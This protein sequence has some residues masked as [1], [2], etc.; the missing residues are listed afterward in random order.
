[1]SLREVDGTAGAPWERPL[2]GSLDR[3]VVQSELLEGNPLGDPTRRPLYIYQPPGLARRGGGPVPS[4]YVL[5]GFTGQLDMW[6]SRAEFAPNI[7]ERLDAM[8]AAG[9]CPDAVIVFVDAWTS[10]GGSQ[11]LN[12]SSTG[13]YLDYICDEIVPFVDERYPTLADRDHRGLSGKS[14]GGYGAM[15]VPMLRPDVFGALASHAG[16]A[17]FECCYLPSFPGVARQLRDDFDGSFDVFLER[18]AEAETFEFRRFGEPLSVWGYACAYSPDPTRPGR[19]LIPFDIATGRLE[20]AI[21]RRWLA[22]DPVR[23]A[24]DHAGALDSMRRIYLDAGRSDEWFLDL[25]A[26]A[27]SQELTSLGVRHTLELFDGR[28]GGISYRYPGAI[29]ELVKALG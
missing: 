18:L 14:S 24:P 21:W 11:F 15:V 12:S 6:F 3:I 16:D 9:D 22:L 2:A 28:H 10:V 29:R 23:M 1:M 17:L 25:G 19:A 8:F 13:R 20:E 4:V 7:F 5:Q 27:F 26:Q